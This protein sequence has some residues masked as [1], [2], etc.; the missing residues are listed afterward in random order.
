VNTAIRRAARALIEEFLEEFP[1]VGYE[2]PEMGG[3]SAVE[4]TELLERL[5]IRHRLELV[6]T[7]ERARA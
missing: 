4:G 7:D 2:E 3:P 6:D 1:T 5:L